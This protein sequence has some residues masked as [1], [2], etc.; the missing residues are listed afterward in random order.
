MLECSFFNLHD[1]MSAMEV[2]SLWC[3]CQKLVR[4]SLPRTPGSFDRGMGHP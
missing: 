1:A 3:V 4:H 2:R